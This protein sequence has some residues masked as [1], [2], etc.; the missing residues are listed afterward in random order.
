M[1]KKSEIKEPE[2]YV[3]IYNVIVVKI[4]TIY[5]DVLF[6]ILLI[7]DSGVGKTSVKLRYTKN[8]FHEEFLNSIGVDF[9]SKDLNIDGRKVKLQIWDTAGQER[10]RTITTSYYRGA[11]AIVIVFDLTKRETYEHVQKWMNDINR[12]AKENVLKL[13]IGNKSDLTNEVKVSYEEVRALASQMKAT[14]FSVSAK[15]NENI[16]EFFEAATKI[17]LIKNNFY[18]EENKAIKLNKNEYK[19]KGKNKYKKEN[20]KNDNCW[21]I[22]TDN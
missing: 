11:H 9:K 20:K 18:I 4:W 21:F 13:I 15:K 8:V 22:I 2:L 16:N 5:R 12:F 1:K 10:F 17:F 3:E 6:K 14:Y 7:G 19:N